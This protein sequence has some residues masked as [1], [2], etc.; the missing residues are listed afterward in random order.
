MLMLERLKILER[1]SFVRRGLKKKT[2][3]QV[4][5]INADRSVNADDSVRI[6]IDSLPER[7][8]LKQLSALLGLFEL[9]EQAR[10]SVSS[11]DDSYFYYFRR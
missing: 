3:I 6:L 8:G 2:G 9:S 5:D 4:V 10:T 11:M 7:A 1:I